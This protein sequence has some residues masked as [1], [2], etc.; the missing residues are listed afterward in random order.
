MK[1]KRFLFMFA[2][3]LAMAQGAWAQTTY[4]VTHNDY[5][6]KTGWTISPT[7]AAEGATVS[8]SYSGQHKVKSV[9]VKGIVGKSDL[10]TGYMNAKSKVYQLNEG[11]MATFTFVNHTDKAA[12]WNNF[13]A[14]VKNSADAN[15]R[16]LRGDAWDDVLNSNAGI[17]SYFDWNT[18]LND[19][20]GAT[21][22][23]TFKYYNGKVS[24]HADV[25]T[26]DSRTFYETASV[27][28]SGTVSVCMT[29][30]NGCYLSDVTSQKSAYNTNIIGEVDN[31]NVYQ[32]VRTQKVA[33]ERGQTVTYSFTNYTSKGG[34]WTNFVAAASDETGEI[35]L[36]RADAWDNRQNNYQGGNA[37]ITNNF[38]WTTFQDDMDG[39]SVVLTY[40]YKSNGQLITR[41]DI[42]TT[43]NH[44][45]YEEYEFTRAALGT[46]TTWVTLELSHLVLSNVTTGTA[47]TI[48][49]LNIINPVV[50]QV[51]G[52][53]G[54]NYD[55][56]NLPPGVNAEAMI[57]YVNGNNGLALAMADEDVNKLDWSS[58]ITTA[59]THLAPFTGGTWKLATKD[60]WTNMVIDVSHSVELRDGFASVGGTNLQADY[61]WSATE[62]SDT[63][64]A[65]CYW[66]NGQSGWM[67][68]PKTNHHY[69]RACLVF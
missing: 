64:R 38:N 10:S 23:V 63:S 62:R 44:S 29:I 43:S 11:E 53:D 28:A 39:A 30:G 14:W 18:F 4:T 65:N 46:L 54:R 60:E 50:K 12:N 57:W 33:I 41:A 17:V 32:G 7:E 51:I 49:S 24:I 20:D 8:V 25:T 9:T 27:D 19:I 6:D 22:V 68:G 67:H 1:K 61:Y 48:P 5:S 3:L 13:I 15:L 56:E 2:A 21:V 36:L 31:S 45:Y 34:N 69:V 58:A 47:P 35:M 66:F 42:T 40:T 37:G 52:S 16:M 59:A 55:Y 26:T